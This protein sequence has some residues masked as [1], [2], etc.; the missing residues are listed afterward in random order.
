MCGGG[1]SD[2]PSRYLPKTAE[3]AVEIPDVGALAARRAAI[4]SKLEGVA[5]KEQIDLAIAEV[6]RMLS[7]DPTTPEGLEA[8][9][10]PKKGAAAV[11]VIDSGRGALWVVPVGNQEKMAATVAELVKSRLR[12]E[13]TREEKAEGA[14]ITV[15]SGSFGPDKVVLAAHAFAKGFL[16]VGVGSK[17][18]DAVKGALARKKEDSL[19]AHPEHGP[20]VF[21]LGDGLVRVL[22]PSGKETAAK[23]AAAMDLPTEGLAASV[24]SVGWGLGLD[25]RA[26]S[27]QLRLR[28]DDAGKKTIATILPARGAAPAGVRAVLSPDAVFTLAAAGD[29]DALLAALAP[30]GSESEKELNAA[31][32]RINSEIGIHP[33]TQLIANMSGHGAI[34]LGIADVTMIANI[35]QLMMN[36]ARALWSTGA[37]GLKNPEPVKQLSLFGT[38]V[39]P[40]L[41]AK[42]LARMSRKVKEQDVSV[43]GFAE[44][45]PGQDPMLME[46]WVSSNAWVFSNSAPRT[47][48]IIA[49]EAKAPADPLDGKSGILATA[50]VPPV[51]KALRTLDIEALAGGGA[52]AIMVRGFLTKA[53]TILDRLD[54]V[55]VRVE[56]TSDGVGATARVVFAAPAAAK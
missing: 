45:P 8:A 5:T 18:L 2:P 55:D 20:L 52:E 9:G 48:A 39:D 31:F 21:S 41:A 38:A 37:F 11:E 54:R 17:G 27:V 47:D 36:P 23:L 29:L 56:P 32:E 53:L 1:P 25:E 30:P 15:H 24:T 40:Q 3:M 10:L 35:R 16:F 46:T 26:I 42:G 43:L 19:V 33:R 28:F 12:V 4:V 34:A 51:T 44:P 14:S 49:D 6:K 22:I 50:H 13:E 7:F